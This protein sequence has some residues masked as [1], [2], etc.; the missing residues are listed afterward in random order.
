MPSAIIASTEECDIITVDS[1]TGAATILSAKLSGEC[2]DQG[3]EYQEYTGTAE[4]APGFIEDVEWIEPKYVLISNCCE[5]ADGRLEV[6]DIEGHD[7]P[8]GF[9]PSGSYPA[10]N[11]QGELVFGTPALSGGLASFGMVS[12]DLNYDDASDPSST[13]LG[14]SGDISFRYL[15]SSE[16]GDTRP[17]SFATR[18][19]WV[20]G[21][22]IGLGIWTLMEDRRFFSWVLLIDLNIGPV[23]ANARGFGWELPTGDEL[24]NL[25]V[26]EQRC[27]L[28]KTLCM[29]LPARVVVVDPQTLVPLYEVEVDDTVVD[30]DLVRGWLLVTL[31]DGRMGTLDLSDG[32]FNVLA[33]GIRNAVWQE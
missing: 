20:G 9:G 33:N 28:F 26:A 3:I 5:P 25:V 2:S 32:T 22:V 18:T 1:Q 14:T 30:M 23:A 11:S 13:N 27:F 12:L 16:G 8:Y 4:I 10:V 7:Q 21:D 19:T 29:G 6:V 17:N 24:G 31:V 15:T